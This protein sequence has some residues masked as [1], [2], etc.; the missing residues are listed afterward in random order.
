MEFGRFVI[1]PT[2]VRAQ[3]VTSIRRLYSVSVCRGRRP[4]ECYFLDNFNSIMYVTRGRLIG[5]G[6]MVQC[7]IMQDDSLVQ[8]INYLGEYWKTP[9]NLGSI[10][11]NFRVLTSELAEQ[12]H[13]V[14]AH[15][16]LNLIHHFHRSLKGR[17]RDSNT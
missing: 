3:K 1:W 15:F 6:G 17:S 13:E 10:R 16:T 5:W 2:S 9:Q 8:R 12:F 4:T 14:H 11:V 7:P